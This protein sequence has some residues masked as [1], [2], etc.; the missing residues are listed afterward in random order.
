MGIISFKSAVTDHDMA[1]VFTEY[2]PT[3]MC[4]V[5]LK[6]ALRYGDMASFR[7]DCSPCCDYLNSLCVTTSPLMLPREVIG[8]H[9]GGNA[10]RKESWATYLNPINFKW[11]ADTL[12]I[13]V[14]EL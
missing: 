9:I 3:H 12:E 5:P 8:V 13:P 10:V 11:I 6:L 4:P 1:V 7:K 2:S 14:K